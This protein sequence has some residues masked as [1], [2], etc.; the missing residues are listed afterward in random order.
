M[1][2]GSSSAV[3]DIYCNELQL[4]NCLAG[5]DLVLNLLDSLLLSTCKHLSSFPVTAPVFLLLL[6]STVA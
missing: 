2:P 1:N 5:E 3:I 6:G 4:S